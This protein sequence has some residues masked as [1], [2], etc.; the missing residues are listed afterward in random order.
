M[1]NTYNKDHVYFLY[2]RKT[3]KRTCIGGYKEL[4]LT[5]AEMM[6]MTLP[7]YSRK[8]IWTEQMFREAI[9]G[10]RYEKGRNV[11]TDQNVTGKDTYI[12]RDYKR[13][14]IRYENGDPVY[15]CFIEIHICD[16]RYTFYTGSETTV[17]IYDLAD[18]VKK[19][20]M[21]P[22]STGDYIVYPDWRYSSTTPHTV[23]ERRNHLH[24]HKTN[25]QFAAA[26]KSDV[27]YRSK[28]VTP[29]P[30][31]TIAKKRSAGWK[32]HKY[33]KQ[34]MHNIENKRLDCCSAKKYWEL[35]KFHEEDFEAMY[36]ESLI[37]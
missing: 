32:D 15:N 31:N 17:N 27:K 18:D 37:A 1:Y 19:C 12:L 10:E 20:L 33:K 26:K 23:R 6:C 22:H 3:G 24:Y 21:M 13:E 2:D 34:W 5:L 30:Y 35:E 7:Y 36:D 9:Y 29:N 16:K 25:V 4:I 11:F 8:Q 14:V 28:S